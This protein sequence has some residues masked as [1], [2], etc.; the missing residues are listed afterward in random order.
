[1]AVLL[2]THNM[3]RVTAVCDSAVVLR[4]GRKTAEADVSQV[5]QDD[6]VAFITGARTTEAPA[7]E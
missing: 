3:D 4:R 5:T 7:R 2:I 1:M 6:L